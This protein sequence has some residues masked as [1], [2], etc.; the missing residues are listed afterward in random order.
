MYKIIYFFSIVIFINT[1]I[2]Q[3]NDN[4]WLIGY[5]YGMG[6]PIPALDFTYGFPDTTALYAPFDMMAA[7]SSICD[8]AGNLLLYTNGIQLANKYHQ[9]LDNSADFNLDSIVSQFGLTN[10]FPYTQSVI[11]IPFPGHSGEYYI[12]HVSGRNFQN[13]NQIQP[14]RLAYSIVNMNLNG[15]QGRMISKNQ[16]VINDT[17]LYSTLQAV[18]HANGRDWW[19]VVHEYNSNKFYAALLTP[20]GIQNIVSSGGGPEIPSGFMGQSCFSPD[21]G[22]YAIANRDSNQLFIYTFDRCIGTFMYDTIIRHNYS[23]QGVNFMGCSFSAYNRYLY[24]SDLHSLYQYDLYSTDIVASEKLIASFDGIG[25]PGVTYIVYHCM[26]PDNKIYINTGNAAQHLHV[27]NA[28]DQPDTNCNFVQRQQKII[29]FQ[30]SLPTF[31]NYRLG[32]LISSACDS[33]TNGL[34]TEED[35]KGV[36]RVW[37]NPSNGIFNFVFTKSIDQ[38]LQIEI[39]N[40]YGQIVFLDNNSIVNLESR[41]SGLYF[42]TVT[43]RNGNVYK[44]RLIKG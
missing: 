20:N 14:V 3:Q 39:R 44:G 7:N 9:L 38:I 24:A 13:L 12:F 37:P 30:S 25:D 26:G 41:A 11:I 32:S 40:V 21:G 10:Y 8:S 6:S 4:V 15:G 16:T 36:L 33:L 31:P 19:I 28:P 22:R 34:V 29:N 5:Q 23:T 17:I 1:T 2:A 18:K 35:N 43:L 27:I 42:Y